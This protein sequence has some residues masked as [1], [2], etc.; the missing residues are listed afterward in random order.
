[1]HPRDITGHKIH[2]QQANYSGSTLVIAILEKVRGLLSSIS[3]HF[4]NEFYPFFPDIDI[5][6]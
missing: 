4:I 2:Q 5:G 1:M 6:V 3:E